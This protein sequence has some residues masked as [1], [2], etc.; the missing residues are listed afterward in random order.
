[1]M[2][3][4]KLNITL[5]SSIAHGLL[6]NLAA[7]MVNDLDDT[8]HKKPKLALQTSKL[9]DNFSDNLDNFSDN[10]TNSI[11]NPTGITTPTFQYK[12]PK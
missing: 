12:K 7:Q 10:P 5:F 1:M 4:L 9:L 3:N 8:H 6:I 11:N 2:N